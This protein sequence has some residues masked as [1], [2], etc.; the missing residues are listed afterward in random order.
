M[1]LS[2]Y[3]VLAENARQDKRCVCQITP[4]K[5]RGVSAGH[6][7]VRSFAATGFLHSLYIVGHSVRDRCASFVPTVYLCFCDV[8]VSKCDMD[9]ALFESERYLRRLEIYCTPLEERREELNCLEGESETN[10][11]EVV[12]TMKYGRRW[13]IRL[14]KR[15]GRK[16]T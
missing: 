5:T 2:T 3:E 16:K 4:D 6:D 10:H 14:C 11:N 15:N 1:L 7:N 9:D 12:R 8:I 13:L